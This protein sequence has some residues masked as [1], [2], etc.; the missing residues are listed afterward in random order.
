MM[1]EYSRIKEV[2]EGDARELRQLSIGQFLGLDAVVK[3]RKPAVA[4]K[5]S[6]APPDT[7]WDSTD[8]DGKHLEWK[9]LEPMDRTEIRDHLGMAQPK[10]RT[11]LQT[12]VP[13]KKKQNPWKSGLQ[14]FSPR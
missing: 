5:A 12:S 14:W 13:I 4:W 2:S 8:T 11:A 7:V 6:N 10:R 1:R 9:T 3:Q